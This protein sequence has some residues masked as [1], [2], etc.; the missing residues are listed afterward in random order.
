[1]FAFGQSQQGQAAVAH[2]CAC[3]PQDSGFRRAH[4]QGHDT[5]EARK[6][7]WPSALMRRAR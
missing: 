7:D 4:P 6:A 1:L 5:G 2:F 3:R